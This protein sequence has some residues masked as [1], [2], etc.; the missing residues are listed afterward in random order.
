MFKEFIKKNEKKRNERRRISYFV[1]GFL[2]LLNG[3]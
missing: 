2:S 3:K 1:C